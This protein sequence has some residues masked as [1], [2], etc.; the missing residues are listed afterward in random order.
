MQRRHCSSSND[1]YLYTA[2]VRDLRGSND[3]VARTERRQRADLREAM[4]LASATTQS[5]TSRLRE[6]LRPLD[7]AR[8][9]PRKGP[10]DVTFVGRLDPRDPGE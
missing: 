5:H 6:T 4:P 1:L 9:T 7:N 3:M 10:V 2:T 8:Q